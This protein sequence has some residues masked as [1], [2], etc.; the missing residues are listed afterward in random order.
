ML[1]L[2]RRAGLRALAKT[3]A[4]YLSVASQ[5][6]AQSPDQLSWLSANL[7]H[8][9]TAQFIALLRS[10][11]PRSL[12]PALAPLLQFETFSRFQAAKFRNWA[13]L[14][15]LS[16]LSERYEELGISLVPAF[17]TLTK[18][19]LSKEFL[20]SMNLT[21]AQQILSAHLQ[22]LYPARIKNLFFPTPSGQDLFDLVSEVLS[23]A[24]SSASD[25]SIPEWYNILRVYILGDKGSEDFR[26][27]LESLVFERLATLP[28]HTLVDL[29]FIY[30][31]RMCFDY[32]YIMTKITGPYVQEVVRRFHLLD[33]R[34]VGLISYRLWWSLGK[35]GVYYSSE[36]TDKL[37]QRVDDRDWL[38]LT[39]PW[40]Q[41][42]FASNVLTYLCN[43]G[44]PL[45]P[46]LLDRLL[47]L[48][49][50]HKTHL[51]AKQ[52]AQLA[53]I[54]ARLHYAREDFWSLVTDHL[55]AIV[56]DERQSGY[57]YS[58]LLQL[59]FAQ[60]T[61]HS[62]LMS[63]PE[64]QASFPQFAAVWKQQ[65]AQDLTL[66]KESF[67]AKKVEAFLTARQIKYQTEYFDEYYIDVAVPELRLALEIC[68]TMHYI[69]P[70]KVLNGKTQAKKYVLE[71]LGWQVVIIP[72]FHQGV[73]GRFEQVLND[74]LGPYLP[75]SS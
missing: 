60:P 38:A 34:Q 52:V 71:Q 11:S 30:R 18:E 46:A 61:L 39:A 58:A 9:S 40:S 70:M 44:L 68:G 25:T 56:Q 15:H 28:L 33:A 31:D 17:Q 48:L 42:Y 54:V 3:P 69:M 36:F 55:P 50:Q 67:Q 10:H 35:Y 20:N 27:G 23:P 1:G 26:R 4:E 53:H 45:G 57:L 6:Q 19:H 64:M 22:L 24:M 74:T 29:P 75:S 65:R 72:F 7:P 66:A 73:E 59:R 13:L 21:Q 62:R 32:H 47:D 8:F 49:L 63:L 2:W 37:V 12:S 14:F 5:P 51:D 16:R 41:V 43:V